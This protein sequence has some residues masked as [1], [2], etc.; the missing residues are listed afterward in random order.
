MKTIFGLPACAWLLRAKPARASELAAVPC[1]KRRR[2][3]ASC[4][5]AMVFSS[6]R[7]RFGRKSSTPQAGGTRGLVPRHG[8]KAVLG[9][10]LSFAIPWVEEGVHEHGLH[11]LPTRDR[12]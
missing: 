4:L 1:T 7:A 12:F 5:R 8:Q 10:C 11:Q 2:V 6:L 3:S 9:G